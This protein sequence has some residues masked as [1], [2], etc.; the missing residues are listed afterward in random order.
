MSRVTF[1][2]IEQI[3][4]ISTHGQGGFW[5]TC[6]ING[7]GIV[8]LRKG[9]A[10]EV[11]SV[12]FD[13]LSSA[14]P[15]PELDTLEAWVQEYGADVMNVAY[16][17][18]HNYHQAQ[19][20][21]QDVFLRAFSK[22]DSFRGDSS[23]KTWLLSITAN[24]CK[25]FLRSWAIRNEVHDADKLDTERANSNTETEVVSHL[26][27]DGLWQAVYELPLKYREVIV[28]YYSREMTSS[29][30]A[31]TLGISEQ[32]VRT[33]LHR[34][35]LMLKERLAEGGDIYEGT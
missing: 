5:Y 11:T 8:S 18:V 28:L 30:I 22:M 6:H 7:N 19:D 20:I 29:E 21:T 16:S 17:Y 3:R 23:V 34:G 2:L 15:A 12:L 4:K 25:D 32:S 14:N 10:S 35:R 31:Q 9:A 26:Q 27:N 1:H 24:R 33:R 13:H